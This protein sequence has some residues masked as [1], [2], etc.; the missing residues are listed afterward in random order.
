MHAAVV[1][2]LGQSPKFQEFNEPSVEEGEILIDVRAI[3]LHP[4]V[5]ALAAGAHYSSKPALPLVAVSNSPWPATTAW[6]SLS[7]D[8]FTARDEPLA[9]RARPVASPRTPH[10]PHQ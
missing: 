5:R 2:V 1:E 4:I 3:G 6:R 8:S 10:A 9:Q 7:W